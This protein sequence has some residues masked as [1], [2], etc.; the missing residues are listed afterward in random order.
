MK[1]VRQPEKVFRV[2]QEQKDQGKAF[3]DE[4]IAAYAACYQAYTALDEGFAACSERMQKAYVDTSLT[5]E[6]VKALE[7]EV[8]AR[9]EALNKNVQT[10]T[11]ALRSI[12][13]IHLKL[14][15]EVGT[16]WFVDEDINEVIVAFG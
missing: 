2:I 11:L 16:R 12:C 13:D 9:L 6:Q 8:K 5:E 14:E 1:Y 15:W 10:T 4:Q 3:T 7:K